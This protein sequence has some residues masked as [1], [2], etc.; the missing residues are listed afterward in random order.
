MNTDG[1]NQV[2]LSNNA[3]LENSPYYSTDGSKIIFF[4]LRDGNQ[5][6]YTMNTDGS[7]QVRVTNNLVPDLFPT[8]GII[9]DTVVPNNGDANGDGVFDVS[10]ANVTPV[11]NSVFIE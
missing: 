7:N 1:S 8:F 3:S 11:V 9:G 5:E 6:I 10:Q 2:N 4:S